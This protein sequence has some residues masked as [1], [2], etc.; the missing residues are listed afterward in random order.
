MMTDE[1]YTKI[2]NFMTPGAG[3]LVLRR[4]HIIHIIKVYQLLSTPEL[5]SDKLSYLL[6]MTRDGSTK[7][8]GNRAVDILNPKATRFF[9]GFSGCL[10]PDEAD[11]PV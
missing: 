9:C 10:Q 1:G 8:S 11:G 4:G 3:V 7:I 2:V 5:R 6:M